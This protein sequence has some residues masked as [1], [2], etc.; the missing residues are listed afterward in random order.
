STETIPAIQHIPLALAGPSET[1][2]SVAQFQPRRG[3][4]G[5]SKLQACLAVAV[6]RVNSRLRASDA[7]LSMDWVIFWRNFIDEIADHIA[8]LSKRGATGASGSISDG[9]SLFVPVAEEGALLL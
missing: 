6:R 1:V 2:D 9:T 3:R 7:H 4:V 5:R 8:N